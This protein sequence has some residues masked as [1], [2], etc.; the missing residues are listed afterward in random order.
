MMKKKIGKRIEQLIYEGGYNSIA[1]FAKYLRKDNPM[2]YVS[3]DTILNLVKGNGVQE[4]TLIIMSKTLDLPIDC[5]T[6]EYVPILDEYLD[7]RAETRNNEDNCE[8][9]LDIV[10]IIY[11]I[12]RRIYLQTSDKLYKKCNITTLAEF[13]L[14][15]PLFEISNVFEI[16]FRI[17]ADIINREFY[18]FKQLNWLSNT[19]P[20]SPEKSFVDCVITNLRLR[21][22]KEL[23]DEEK[24]LQLKNCEFEKSKSFREGYLQYIHTI[25]KKRDLYK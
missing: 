6:A 12:S 4:N 23:N 16:L 7:A 15:F 1:Q 14:Y 3:E 9:N 8:N 25:Q 17:E 22:K 24:K 10:R 2:N 19:I 13:L 20:D 18:F 11:D 21:S 5:F